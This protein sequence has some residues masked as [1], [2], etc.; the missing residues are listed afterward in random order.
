MLFWKK[1]RDEGEKGPFHFQQKEKRSLCLHTTLTGVT[2]THVAGVHPVKCF[3][4]RDIVKVVGPMEL[5]S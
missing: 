4:V 2:N 5:L 1:C 3:T